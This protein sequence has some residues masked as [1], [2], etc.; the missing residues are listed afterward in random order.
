MHSLTVIAGAPVRLGQSLHIAA[1]IIDP[2]RTVSLYTKQH[3]GAF[4]DCARFDGCLPPPEA[5]IF[6]AGTLDPLV[7]F[8]D[9]LAAIAI[10]ADTGRAS[11]PQ[12]AAGRGA[13]AYLASMFAIPSEFDRD[14]VTLTQYA[15]EHSMLAALANFGSATG[16]LAAAGRS[17]IWSEHG[18]L[19][20]R[21]PPHGAGIAVATRSTDLWHAELAMLGSA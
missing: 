15:V 13:K 3:L 17:S 14:C 6:Q 12:R 9:G 11:H 19:I 20:A 10:C 16:G 18:A 2:K 1:F 8:G 7:P 5:S 21:L 4:G